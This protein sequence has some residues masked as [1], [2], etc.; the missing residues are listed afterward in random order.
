ME[1]KNCELDDRSEENPQRSASKYKDMNNKRLK[2]TQNGIR[3]A[4]MYVG[5]IPKE[6]K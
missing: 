4:C 6:D 2:D 5:R 1:E 3:N